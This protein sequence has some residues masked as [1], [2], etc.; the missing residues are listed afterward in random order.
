M[1]SL[2]VKFFKPFNE[3]T[4]PY[5]SHALTVK[6]YE[7][8]RRICGTFSTVLILWICTYCGKYKASPKIV[9]SMGKYAKRLFGHV[10][11][12]NKRNESK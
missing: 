5:F 10:K 2:Q 11:R 3:G 4:Q 12:A 6:T 9:W 1:V 8:M 7:M